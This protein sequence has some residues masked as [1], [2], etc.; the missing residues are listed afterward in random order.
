MSFK[1]GT[2]FENICGEIVYVVLLGNE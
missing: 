1:G 2:V